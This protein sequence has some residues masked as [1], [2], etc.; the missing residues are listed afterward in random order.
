[1]TRAERD[2]AYLAEVLEAWRAA[3]ATAEGDNMPDLY[4]ATA[5]RAAADDWT[6]LRPLL[7]VL[8]T[9]LRINTT[10]VA[11]IGY[12]LQQS[13]EPGAD[14]Q[15]AAELLEV[16]R[17]LREAQE[18]LAAALR[19][20]NPQPG[21]DGPGAGRPRVPGYVI[22][23][24]KGGLRGLLDIAAMA[25]VGTMIGVGV[26]A[27]SAVQTARLWWRGAPT[28]PTTPSDT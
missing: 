22:D 25:G 24:Q 21:V 3:F 6:Q 26:G 2:S 16:S 7:L 4:A 10:F 14:R 17:L 5:R 8:R 28:P 23:P 11:Q 20:T 12:S 18:P 19:A 13:I 27:S 1:M 9:M 15:T